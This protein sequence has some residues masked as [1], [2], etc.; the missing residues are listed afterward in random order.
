MPTTLTSY[1]SDFAVDAK[2]EQLSKILNS[3]HHMRLYSS[4]VSCMR[5]QM[6]LRLVSVFVD[7]EA[8]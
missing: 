7:I 1:G 8:L 3:V 2:V 5:C 4:R 6:E